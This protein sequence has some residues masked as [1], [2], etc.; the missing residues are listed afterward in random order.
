VR[1]EKERNRRLR[2]VIR[3]RGGLQK[4]KCACRAE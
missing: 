4:R 3:E 2:D 1:G